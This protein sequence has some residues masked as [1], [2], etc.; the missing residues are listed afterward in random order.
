MASAE[1][2][3]AASL[4]RGFKML[5]SVP[6]YTVS[7]GGRGA[8]VA[9]MSQRYGDKTA[10]CASFDTDKDLGKTAETSFGIKH[11]V[12][13]I[14]QWELQFPGHSEWVECP[15]PASVDWAGELI[16]LIDG[17]DPQL[18]CARICI[19][20]PT[21]GKLRVVLLPWFNELDCDLGYQWI[22]RLARNPHSGQIEGDGIRVNDFAIDDSGKL[23]RG[24]GHRFF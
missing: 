10:R 3:H 6:R 4:C 12:N 17:L 8:V 14:E 19:W 23:I 18:R 1:A 5:V 20:R 22:T 2:Q 24:G 7:L 16:F 11:S 13:L 21:V 15:L 9:L